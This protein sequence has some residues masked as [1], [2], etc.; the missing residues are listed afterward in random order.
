[1]LNWNFMCNNSFWVN[2]SCIIKTGKPTRL[3]AWTL[4]R[5]QSSTL[6]SRKKYIVL[7]WT[8][9][10]LTHQWLYAHILPYLLYLF[11]HIF[12]FKNCHSQVI[13]LQK[14]ICPHIHCTI[15]VNG[16]KYNPLM[17]K[18]LIVF[19]HYTLSLFMVLRNAT[20]CYDIW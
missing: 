13:N 9:S 11:H 20:A 17:D 19:Q 12:A 16:R 14:M 15:T 7:V 10:P 1:M 18:Y 6:G 3:K 8:D 2:V 4:T 5:E